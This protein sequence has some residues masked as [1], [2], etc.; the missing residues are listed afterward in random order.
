MSKKELEILEAELVGEPPAA[1]KIYGGVWGRRH[2]PDFDS[3]DETVELDARRATPIIPTITFC[4]KKFEEV[5]LMFALPLN[6]ARVPQLTEKFISLV[7]DLDECGH[8]AVGHPGSP[9]IRIFV[10]TGKTAPFMNAFNWIN[11]QVRWKVVFDTSKNDP[12]GGL[13]AV[14]IVSQ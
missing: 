8:F 13:D 10:P 14:L 7:K 4:G 2:I 5:E 3:V 9:E 12:V 11:S 6:D 1:L